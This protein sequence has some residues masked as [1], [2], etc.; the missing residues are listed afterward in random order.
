SVTLQ[1]IGTIHLDPS[2]SIPQEGDKNITVPENAFS[3]EYN[4]RAGED[5]SL[6]DFIVQQTRK[7][8]PLAS[9]D[10]ESYSILAKQFLNIG[11][12]L[13]IEGIGTIL[14]NQAGAYDF[15]PGHFVSPKIEDAPKQL[16][17]KTEENISFENEAPKKGNNRGLVLFIF[18]V[19]FASL[20]A[21]GLYYF[22]FK[23]KG[24]KKDAIAEEQT[25]Q[26]PAQDTTTT[27]DTTQTTLDTTALKQAEAVIK[28]S[29]NFK[30]V[31]REY[32]N[33]A[34]ANKA[35]TRFGS[36]GY[37]Q[38]IIIKVDSTKYR[39][40]M[41]FT[42]P[43]ADTLKVRDSLKRIFVGKPYIITQ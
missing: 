28:D 8:K 37:T 13:T 38:L 14:K 23:D 27:T 11:K 15:I 22:I 41:P 43:L 32:P 5:E 39:L 10:L 24:P 20:T 35:L 18:F 17:E 34:A 6:I 21:L 9:S 40:A 30:V 42:A 2:V 19:L 12:P 25:I 26:Q 31:I 4:L 16:K 3:F 29:S 36:F 1:G 33:E 7:I